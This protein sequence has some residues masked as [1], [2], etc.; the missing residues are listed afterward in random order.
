MLS[1]NPPQKRSAIC[2]HN[3]SKQRVSANNV[4][5]TQSRSDVEHATQQA[6]NPA[7]LEKHGGHK[8]G[9]R[10]SHRGIQCV[11]NEGDVLDYASVCR[12]AYHVDICDASRPAVEGF[13][14]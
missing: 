2:K 1:C 3:I 9:I 13:A 10:C 6:S 12:V 14:R 4:S 8:S 5:D 11:D 7:R